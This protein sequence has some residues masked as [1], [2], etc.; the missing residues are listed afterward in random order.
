MTSIAWEPGMLAQVPADD[1]TVVYVH[2]SRIELC[3]LPLDWNTRLPYA[4]YRFHW[5]I[6]VEW[7]DHNQW[8]VLHSSRFCLG[9]DGEWDWEPSPSNRE[10]DWKASHRFPLEEALQLAVQWAPKIK[11]NGVTALDVWNRK[12]DEYLK[13]S[14]DA[15]GEDTRTDSQG[16][17]DNTGS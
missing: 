14:K 4:D 3:C 13:G 9:T 10:D 5:M 6:T 7:R 11:V 17:T 12:K 15:A 1:G 2:G 8:A 16:S